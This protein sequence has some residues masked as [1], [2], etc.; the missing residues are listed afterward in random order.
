M[1][2]SPND[3]LTLMKKDE[4]EYYEVVVLNLKVAELHQF[5]V[6]HVMD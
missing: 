3:V 6:A 1:S 4:V 2:V 5:E